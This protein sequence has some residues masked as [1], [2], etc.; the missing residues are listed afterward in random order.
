[1]AARNRINSP[2]VGESDIDYFGQCKFALEPSVHRLAEMALAA[3]W[4]RPKV[5]YALMLLA[6]EMTSCETGR[7]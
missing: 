6:M 1:M 3:G 5:G 7:A 2:S 4:S